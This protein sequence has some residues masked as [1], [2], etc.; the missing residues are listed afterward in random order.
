LHALEHGSATKDTVHLPNCTAAN[1]DA[2]VS[3][4]IALTVGKPTLFTRIY[5]LSPKSFDMTLLAVIEPELWPWKM[6]EKNFVPLIIQLCLELR[7]LDG[8]S[9]LDLSFGYDVHRNT[10][11]L[12]AGIECT[13]FFGQ[14]KTTHPWCWRWV[15]SN[16]EWVYFTF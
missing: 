6:K 9:Y 16:A 1:Y 12:L 13:D 7:L 10:V 14:H 11:Q 3:K 2:V 5:R 4:I 15:I 8:G